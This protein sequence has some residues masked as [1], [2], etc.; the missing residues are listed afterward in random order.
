MRQ[1]QSSRARAGEQRFVHTVLRQLHDLWS[2][3]APG[4][5]AVRQDDMNTS[6]LHVEMP[7][8][9]YDRAIHA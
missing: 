7:R 4:V 3:G 9:I 2:G 8:K 5:Q 1:F 6:I